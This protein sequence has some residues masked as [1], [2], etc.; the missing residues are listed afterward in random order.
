[1]RGEKR[2]P[3]HVRAALRCRLDAVIL[4]D[5]RDCVAGHVVAESLETTAD[6]GVSPGRILRGQPDHQR[7]AVGL[8]TWAT[9]AALTRAIRFLRPEHPIPP[10]D[11]VR[12]HNARGV[13]Q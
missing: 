2:L 4:H 3:R 11:G 1:M 12:G 6:A 5:R 13:R 7:G 10:P 8:R 9:W